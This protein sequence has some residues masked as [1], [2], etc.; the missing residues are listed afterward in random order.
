MGWQRVNNLLCV[1][2]ADESERPAD[3]AESEEEQG[4]AEDL[5]EAP[6][7]MRDDARHLYRDA[8]ENLAKKIEEKPAL[9]QA[10]DLRIV[11]V[12]VVVAIALALV[13]SLLGLSK[14]FI[15]VVF[16]VAFA[17]L[18]WG[19]ATASAARRPTSPSDGDSEGE[20]G[21]GSEAEGGSE[22]KETS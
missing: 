21:G 17:G 22:A 2:A 7:A 8:D 13:V 14:P 6:G 4:L 1:V 10:L 15:L 20:D 11:L 9:E 5:K 12:A 3:G 19:L 18:W 16:V